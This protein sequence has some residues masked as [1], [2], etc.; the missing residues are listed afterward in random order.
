[1]DSDHRDIEVVEGDM[2]E[3]FTDPIEEAETIE[4]RAQR[5]SWVLEERLRR[6]NPVMLGPMLRYRGPQKRI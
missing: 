1:M 3:G 2:G 6:R 5:L 4:D